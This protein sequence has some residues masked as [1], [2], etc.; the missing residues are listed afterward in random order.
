[1]TP[2][3]LDNGGP[4]VAGRID[5]TEAGAP[6]RLDLPRVIVRGAHER[7]EDFA[8]TGRDPVAPAPSPRRRSRRR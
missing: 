6:A 7:G 1:M 8:V 4:A 5:Q 2:R 3:G